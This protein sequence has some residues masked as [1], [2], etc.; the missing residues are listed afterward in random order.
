MQ[1]VNLKKKKPSIV[2]RLLCGLFCNVHHIGTLVDFLDVA[3]GC[4][5]TTNLEKIKKRC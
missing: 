2:S 1:K 5:T 4:D 3:G